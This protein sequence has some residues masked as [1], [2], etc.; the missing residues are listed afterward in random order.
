MCGR[1]DLHLSVAPDEKMFRNL[2]H[3]LVWNS[4]PPC[5]NVATFALVRVARSRLASLRNFSSRPAIGARR[6]NC[7][8][9]GKGGE[10]EGPSREGSV[11]NDPQFEPFLQTDFNVARFTSNVLAGSQT[12][13]QAQAE[14]LREGVRVLDAELRSEVLGRSAELLGHVKRMTC[15]DESLRD[16]VLGVDSLQA[17]VKRIRGE[18][19]GPYDAVKKKTRQL[20]NLHAT[21]DLLRLLIHRIKLT[22]KL[23]AQLD[24]APG[25]LDL[26]KAAKLITDIRS[27]D[28]EADLSGIDA[29]TSD[30]AFLAQATT[31]VRQQAEV[32]LKACLQASLPAG[33]SGMGP[34]G[35][36]M[37]AHACMHA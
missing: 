14:Q 8:A 33:R 3:T 15:A 10:S 13:A 23:K 1:S 22:Q 17:A 31:T 11:L 12:T 24:A 7:C 16:V 34:A 28:A 21:I 35:D 9:M 5:F 36:C 19:V 29:V 27:V 4:P 32:R 18:I 2:L 6:R 20:H 37:V 26:A 25:A 30:A